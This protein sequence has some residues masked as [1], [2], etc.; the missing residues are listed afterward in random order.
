MPTNIPKIITHEQLAAGHADPPAPTDPVDI[1]P[2][3]RGDI[4]EN[5][6]TP[7]ALATHSLFEGHQA[8]ER[9]EKADKAGAL[10]SLD[11]AQI[12]AERAARK[13]YTP[14]TSRTKAKGRR[15]R[16]SHRVPPNPTVDDTLRVSDD[17]AVDL[18]LSKP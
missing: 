5:R 7:Y 8:R 11:N 3:Q 18:D 10:A 6:V 2:L 1:R 13:Q 12:T 4:V 15:K 16:Q 17:D 9:A 14:A